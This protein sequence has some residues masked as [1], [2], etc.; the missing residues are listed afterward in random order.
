MDCEK[1]VLNEERNVTLTA[2]V[3][4][5]GGNEFPETPKRPAV[6]VLPGGGYSMCSDREADP[7]ALAYARAGFQ[8]FI[9]RYSV[10]KHATWPNP[11][12]DCE[13]AMA[14]I[15][16]N[17][18]KWGVYADKIAVIGFS[19]GGHLAASAATMSKNRPNAAIL[20]YAVTMGEFV[21]ECLTSAP[22][23]VGAVSR[24]TCP[25]FLFATRT[26]QIVPIQDTLEFASAL[27]KAGVSFECHIYSYGPHGFSTA[28]DDLLAHGG[29]PITARAKNWVNDS[30]GWLHELFG[31]FSEKGGLTEPVVGHY[32]LADQGEY[33]SV[34]CSLGLLM[35]N[36]QTREVLAPFM[37]GMANQAQERQANS[38]GANMAGVAKRISLRSALKYAKLPDEM[39]NKVDEKLRAIKIQA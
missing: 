16:A 22:D 8:T 27:D 9:L 26:D 7:V 15:R 24:E 25:C 32:A 2:Y 6:L 10:A 34:D 18:D 5:T 36:E 14:L 1:I 28:E 3:L 13:Q 4:Q 23:T 29:K 20:G 11:L 39:V 37:S 21:H 30:I 38:S 35:S 12:E 31:E 17:A 19:A 33:F